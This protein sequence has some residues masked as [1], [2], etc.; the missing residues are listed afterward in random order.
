MRE[1]AGQRAGLGFPLSNKGNDL[2]TS[3]F[4][5]LSF[6]LPIV[7]VVRCSAAERRIMA[8]T[9]APRRLGGERKCGL[10]PAQAAAQ[11]ALRRQR[12]AIWC[13]TQENAENGAGTT[14][15]SAALAQGPKGGLVRTASMEASTDDSKTS[16]KRIRS[17]PSAA[18]PQA[19]RM[20][21]TWPCAGCTFENDKPLAVVC[22]VC[23]TQR[24][25]QM[26]LQPGKR[27]AAADPWSCQACT[28]I[29]TGDQAQ[30]AVCSTQST[31]LL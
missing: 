7:H 29:N 11:A 12:D 25:Q 6:T 4:V 2:G 18:Q 5:V 10:T 22:T 17:S 27:A 3:H 9:A 8:M 30:C 26:Q 19:K 23:G 13:G 16:K 28:F 21:L 31:A 14:C 15:A 20:I 24:Q 1:V